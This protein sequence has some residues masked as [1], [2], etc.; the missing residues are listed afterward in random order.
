MAIAILNNIISNKQIYHRN[1]EPEMAVRDFTVKV[2]GTVAYD[3]QSHGSFEATGKWVGQF[4]GLI[5][6]HSNTDSL[7]HFRQ[8]YANESA[9]ITQVLDLLAPSGSPRGI[10]TLATAAPATQKVVTSFVMEIS[11]MVA[12]DDNSKVGY[13]AQWINGVV[14]LY[15]TDTL[16]TWSELAAAVSSGSSP[17]DFL[18]LVFAAFADTPGMTPN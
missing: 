16:D 5:A 14:S 3:D 7:E 15:P 1:Q 4:G 13:V 18:V 12:L 8:L 6:Q 10:V 9:G 11:G 17:R 2:S